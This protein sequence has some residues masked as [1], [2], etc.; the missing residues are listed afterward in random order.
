MCN[1]C[2]NSKVRNYTHSRTSYHLKQLKKLFKQYKKNNNAPWDKPII[3]K[4]PK[5]AL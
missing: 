3:N 2:K 5:W 4:I 1:L